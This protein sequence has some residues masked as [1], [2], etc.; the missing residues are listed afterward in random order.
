MKVLVTDPISNAGISILNDAGLDVAYE[1]G[2]S[3]IEK[4]EAAHDADGLII[5]S[6]TQVDSKMIE[7]AQRLQV[8]GR[9]GVGI[10]N[11]DIT[12][13]TRKGIVVMN[14][15]DV[16]TISAAEHTLALMLTLSR[17]THLGHTSLTSGSWDRHKLIGTELQNKTIGILGLGKIGRE[18]MDRCR[19]F[20]MKILGFD[21]FIN[22]GLFSEADI[23][24]TSLDEVVEKSDYVSLHMPLNENTRDLLNY[25]RFQT[26]KPTAKIINVARGGI[27][28]EH[29]L[30]RALNEDIISGAAIDVFTIEPIEKDNP[31][32]NAKN[33]LLSPHLGASTKEAKEG[34]SIAICEQVRDYLIDQ[35]LSNALNLPIPNISLL[36]KIQPFLDLGE[37]L[38]DLISQLNREPIERILIECQGAI[39]EIRPISLAILKG[40]LTP[41]L[42]DRIN[43]V[44]AETIAKELGLDVE[45]R[46]SNSESSYNNVISLV[47]VTAKKSYQLDG[48]IFD[49]L[50]PR[51]VNVLGR[52]M[53]I[54]PKGSMLLLENNDVPGVIG[55]V[56]TML[57]DRN[58]NIAAYLLDR[59]DQNGKA[60]GVIRLDNTV[61]QE[62]ILLLR[63]LEEI[64]WVGHV[65]VKA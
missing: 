1:A 50:K 22:Q 26:M 45:V 55:K 52:K 11:I 7:Y 12:S 14:T 3:Q 61:E 28:N 38:G 29:D 64:E 43:Y 21:P 18:V 8:V 10:D 6:G 31:L 23:T 32:L 58:I 20:G 42:P 49:D 34:V 46:Y 37:L 19:S 44:N 39:E 53:E 9:A 56:G 16:N 63:N 24:I 27:V 13:A 36:K 35:K 4:Y 15:P 60:F 51:L 65:K 48:S 47:V 57:G 2:S 59:R 25:D 40:L 5:R 17:N 30:A 33:I 54:T 41:N 62:D